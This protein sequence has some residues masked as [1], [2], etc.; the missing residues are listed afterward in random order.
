[1]CSL[2]RML[3]SLTLPA[4]DRF[5]QLVAIAAE[6]L[7]LNAWLCP[8]NN[9]T[10]VPAAMIWIQQHVLKRLH[11]HR[12]YATQIMIVGLINFVGSQGTGKSQ[13]I[14]T[15]VWTTVTLTLASPQSFTV[16]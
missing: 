4:C 8:N 13:D 1:M 14:Q 2:F 11:D 3:A 12:M 10:C 6:K 16:L 9:W 5:L 15:R 7:S